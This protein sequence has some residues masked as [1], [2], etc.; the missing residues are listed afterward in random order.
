MH[1][2]KNTNDANNNNG[3]YCWVMP[4][5]CRTHTDGLTY[6]TL[7]IFRAVFSGQYHCPSTDGVG[8]WALKC[9]ATL[10]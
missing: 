10:P 3:I 2:K 8:G 6:G 9:K 5:M 4:R 1:L 7:I